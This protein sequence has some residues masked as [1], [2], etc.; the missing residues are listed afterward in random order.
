MTVRQLT[1]AAAI[2]VASSSVFAVENGA[3]LN[4]SEHPDIVSVSGIGFEGTTECSGTIIARKWVITAA[5]CFLGGEGLYITSGDKTINVKSTHINPNYNTPGLNAFAYDMAILEL[6]ESVSKSREITTD[7]FVSGDDYKLMG[8]AG[9]Q[10]L[11]EGTFTAVGPSI[12]TDPDGYILNSTTYGAES[13]DSGGPIFDTNGQVIGILSSGTHDI[14]V[15]HLKDSSDWLTQTMN[16][17]NYPASV[18]GSGVMTVDIQ[19]L[20]SQPD[21]ITASGDGTVSVVSNTCEGVTL[22]P[23]ATCSI[24]VTGK[25]NLHLTGSDVVTVNPSIKPREPDNDGGSGGGGGSFGF[26]VLGFLGIFAIIV[27]FKNMRNKNV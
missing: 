2:L 23:Y 22:N 11:K 17:W 16:T 27:R 5:H 25:G 13:G 18:S 9:T 19:N 8:Y 26:G 15:R 10:Q 6:N 3:S 14:A 7:E 1:L 4:P 24:K 20:H 21:V 12:D